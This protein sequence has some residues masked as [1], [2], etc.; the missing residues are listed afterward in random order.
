MYKF[1]IYMDRAGQYRFRFVA[2]NGQTMATSEGYTTKQA[3][4]D[5]VNS[6]KQHA[7]TAVIVEL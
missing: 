6:I 4:K 1:E 2:S 3:C 7:A 5:S